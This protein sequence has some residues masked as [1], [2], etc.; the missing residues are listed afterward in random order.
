MATERQRKANR[1]NARKS[2][3]PRTGAGKAIVRLNATKHGLRAAAVVI[4]GLESPAEWEAFRAA[5]VSSLRPSGALAE[6]LAD[7][8]AGLLWRLGRAER[9]EALSVAADQAELE[10]P[11]RPRT[12]EAA[13]REDDEDLMSDAE[14]LAQRERAVAAARAKLARYDPVGRLASRLKNLADEAKLDGGEALLFLSVC[15]E[16]ARA[17][18]ADLVPDPKDHP[19]FAAAAGLD[20]GGSQP[21]TAGAVRQAMSRFAAAIPKK[22]D[23]DWLL[24]EVAEAAD[25]WVEESRTTI[26]MDGPEA[27]SLRKRVELHAAVA[28]ARRAG[29]N[30]VAAATIARYEGHLQRQLKHTMDELERLRRANAGPGT[31]NP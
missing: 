10:I 23:G 5:V 20:A 29:V 8:A 9:A 14:L 16:Q 22:R 15:A 19:A 11:A 30:A 25:E 18:G 6:A 21:W 1:A 2:T 17:A 12:G 13:L 27:D 31:S 3:G 4:P 28:R 26:E 24:A 7:R